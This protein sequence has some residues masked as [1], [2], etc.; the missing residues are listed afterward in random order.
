MDAAS[1]PPFEGSTLPESRGPL[2]SVLWKARTHPVNVLWAKPAGAIWGFCFEGRRY[3][4]FAHPYNVTWLNERAVE[5]PLARAALFENAGSVLE[6]GNVLSHYMSCAHDTVDRYESGEGLIR[7]DICAFEPGKRYDL[8]LSIST[9]EHVGWDER[10]RRPD[11]LL[12]AVSRLKSLL[13]P[14]GRLLA[15]APLG[16]NA[17][18]DGE[19]AA[20]HDLFQRTGFLRRSALFNRWRQVGRDQALDCPYDRDLPTARAL[21]VWRHQG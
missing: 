5:V 1:P 7:S 19:I 20:G 3:P 4:R 10:P 18:L 9:L 13:A 12:D 11:K 6:L 2:R 8:V 15:T 14:G 21:V 17:F 16:Y